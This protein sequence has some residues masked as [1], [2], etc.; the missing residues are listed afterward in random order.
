MG[1]CWKKGGRIG[2]ETW[3]YRGSFAVSVVVGGGWMSGL[4]GGWGGWYSGVWESDG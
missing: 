1:V 3:S 2:W 4:E